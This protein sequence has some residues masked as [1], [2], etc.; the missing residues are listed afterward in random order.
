VYELLD[1]T[2]QSGIT[3]WAREVP[4]TPTCV[5]SLPK[6]GKFRNWITASEIVRIRRLITRHQY[7][8]PDVGGHIVIWEMGRQDGEKII[9]SSSFQAETIRHGNKF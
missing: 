9:D 5:V 8:G 1:Y 3:A 7:H 4:R 6:R 2:R